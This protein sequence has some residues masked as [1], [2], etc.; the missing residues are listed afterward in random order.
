MKCH[1]PS[2]FVMRCHGLPA[3]LCRPFAMPA[4]R[5]ALVSGRSST[6]LCRSFIAWN[7][8]G[9]PQSRPVSTDS[10]P[11]LFRRQAADGADTD[12]AAGLR[13]AKE[14]RARLRSDFHGRMDRLEG[15]RDGILGVTRAQGERPSRMGGASP[16]SRAQRRSDAACPRRIGG[17]APAGPDGAPR[18]VGSRLG[19]VEVRLLSFGDSLQPD[20]AAC[21]AAIER[22]VVTDCGGR[23]TNIPVK[24]DDR[25]SIRETRITV[26]DVP[27][28]LA[29]AAG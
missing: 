25:R 9:G 21:R 14:D 29:F 12:L 19:F 23:S 13:E 4:G 11:R 27:E 17:P 28:Y 18:S 3:L 20:S 2:C 7:R 6:C 10:L 26:C 16:E 8:K 22:R 15:P 5:R 1:D 24:P